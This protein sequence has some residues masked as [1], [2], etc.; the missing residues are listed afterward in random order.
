VT[1]THCDIKC[2][3]FSGDTFTEDETKTHANA[4]TGIPAGSTSSH[5][6]CRVSEG[7]TTE[8]IEVS[9]HQTAIVPAVRILGTW[10]V[11]PDL[12]NG[13]KQDEND[14]RP[15]NVV[16]NPER[17]ATCSS[18]LR[19]SRGGYRRLC[20]KV[21][22]NKHHHQKQAP[23]SA[24]THSLF[25]RIPLPPYKRKRRS[26]PLPAAC[27]T[28]GRGSDKRR[29]RTGRAAK[30]IS[31]ARHTL[32]RCGISRVPPRGKYTS[33]TAADGA[34]LDAERFVVQATRS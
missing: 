27:S 33:A 12:S 16:L 11:A 26:L 7:P 17:P 23:S 15:R 28:T 13:R 20:R 32:G 1:L 2:T 10:H 5:V 4:H 30:I 22:G 6:T 31:N 18:A 34:I 14:H 9:G 25:L 29:E 19:R 3:R 21:S 8:G 24:H